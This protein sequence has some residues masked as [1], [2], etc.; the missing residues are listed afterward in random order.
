MKK[1]K[2]EKNSVQ[3]TLIIPLYGRKVCTERFPGLFQDPAALALMERLDYDFD[4]LKKKVSGPVRQFGALEVA[5]RQTDLSWEVRDYLKDHPRAAVVNL[6][7]GLDQTGENCDNGCCHIYNLDLPDVIEIRKQLIP[8]RD[9][10]TLISAD[11]TDPAW[12][13]RIDAHEGAVFIAAGVFY[14]ILRKDVEKLVNAMAEKFSG[15]RLCFDA[16]GER[17]VK[18]MLR[19]WVKDAGITSI[20]E[21][22]SVDSLEKDIRSWLKKA[23]VTE[24]GYMLGYNDLKNPSV[25]VFFRLLSGVGDRYMGMRILRFDFDRN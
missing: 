1:V 7:C 24:R 10:V 22:F 12:M 20:K 5:M 18:L 23:H 4:A 3:E 17:A 6:G 21:C 16:A 2:I 9:R 13:D 19:T 25:P 8:E 11:L 14:Y 15:G